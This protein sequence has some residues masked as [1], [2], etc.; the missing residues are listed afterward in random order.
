[1][2]VRY[3]GIEYSLVHVEALMSYLGLSSGIV[4]GTLVPLAMMSSIMG[5]SFYSFWKYEFTCE[6]SINLNLL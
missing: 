2:L 6:F 5:S 1:M 3:V 4:T